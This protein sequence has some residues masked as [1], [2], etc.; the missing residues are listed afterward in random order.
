MEPV[1]IRQNKKTLIPMLVVLAVAL[2]G[3]TWYV[4]LSGRFDNNST[5]KLL[6]VFLT[7]SLIYTLY[8][9]T[10]KFIK[11]EPVLKFSHTGLEV[12]ERGRPVSL[13]W[14]QVT[15]WRMEKE[16]DGG[17]HYLII[18]TTEK[19]RKVNLSWLDK[20]PVEIEAL[21]QAYKRG[22]TTRRDH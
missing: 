2:F 3:M 18:D 12:N 6:Y 19:S 15:G 16:E 21:M 22:D 5:M 8:I 10:R 7:A 11:N 20:R 9:P 17:T 1:E 4:F 14:S 13:L